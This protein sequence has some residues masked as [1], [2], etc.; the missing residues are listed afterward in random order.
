M[1]KQKIRKA[2]IPVAGMGTRFLPATKAIPKEMLPILDKPTLQ[3][4]VEEAVAS[5]ITDIIFVTSYTKRACEDH[6]DTSPELETA[7]KKNPKKKDL[8]EKIKNIS[9]MA[10]FYFVRQKGP[11]GN[12]TP[13]LNCKDIIGDEP[14][15]VMWGDEIFDCP[16]NK[17]RLKQQIDVFN[18][19][20]DPV[21][22]GYKTYRDGTSK[23]GI[24]DGIEIEPGVY[25]IKKIIEKPG[26]EKAPSHIA[27]LGAYILTP[28]IFPIL[29]QTKRGKDNELWLVD[30]IFTLSKKRPI[31][32][33]VIDGTFYDTGNKLTWL[34]ANIVFGL[35][36]KNISSDLKKFIKKII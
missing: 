28:D 32:A 33:K 8:Y 13:V 4:V 9:K 5:G 10:N 19:Y 22:T 6:F 18:K 20:G 21:L 14:F 1:T 16:K 27:T 26:P 23:Y 3:Y 25:Q 30:A 35:K 2:I 34:K 12:G 15:A 17:P 11:Y 31:Y 24:I 36:D 29:E 7:L